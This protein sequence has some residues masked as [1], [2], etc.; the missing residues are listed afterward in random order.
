VSALAKLRLRCAIYTRKS[1]EEG[2]EQD[3]NS[4]QA[5]REAC[6]AYI[7]SQAGEGWTAIKTAYD[8]GGVSGGTMERVGLKALLADIAA[9]RI[10]VVVVYKVDRL[11]RSLGDFARI[12]E[13]FDAHGVSFVSVTQAF[14]TTTSMG[15]LTLNVLL[16]FAQF[17][18]EVTGERIRDKIE[19]SKKKGMWMGGNVPLGY[20]PA[21]RSLKINESEATLVR[22]IF[23]RYI[24]LG[25]VH[26][27][28]EVL[29]REGVCSKQRVTRS[30][31]I[32]GGA[33]MNRGAL[34]HLLTNRIYL[35]EIPHKG[36][37]YPG[38]HP[39]I[40]DAETF[41]KVAAI[42]AQ[43]RRRRGEASPRIALSPL[44]GKLFDAQ[45]RPMSP[46]TASGKSGR[47]YR[48]YVSSARQ[49]GR[50]A[51]EGIERLPAPALESLMRRTLVRLAGLPSE[52]DDWPS[53]LTLLERLDL[54]ADGAVLSLNPAALAKGQDDARQSLAALQSQLAEGER[55]WLAEDGTIRVAL[56]MKLVFRGG[57]SWL[58][59]STGASLHGAAARPNRALIA[60]L[61]KGQALAR[62]ANIAPMLKP[63][64]LARATSI[65]DP[66]QRKLANLAFLAPDIQT[67]I[68]AGRQPVGLSLQQVL[69][70][71][72]PL[73]WAE[74][75]ALWGF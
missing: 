20:E 45:G 58:I 44:T 2:L 12:V 36:E 24:Q 6:E 47:R 64:V 50:P 70:A 18:R 11:T 72:M 17:E 74:Q 55:A 21:G 75:R 57:R 35:G 48:Y 4:L 8:D 38:L 42:L 39:A 23:D 1:S 19:A 67:A 29:A 31:A 37:A 7:T 54:G 22:S 73:D 13:T 62:A 16:S 59:S 27:L 40:V 53:F 68:L 26:R 61:R 28:M 49:R 63:S 15:R 41:A 43:N 10:D 71:S 60:G 30:G 9:K 65:D 3:F 69:M 32:V 33:A 14:N 66:Y 52:T 51:G 25:S 34:F 56:A 46:T 5:Q